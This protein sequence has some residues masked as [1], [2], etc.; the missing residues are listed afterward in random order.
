MAL[1]P[2]EVRVLRDGAR[3]VLARN[4]RGT[5]IAPGPHQYPGQWNWD[6]ALIAIGLAHVDPPR[7]RHEVLQLL[8]GQWDNGMVPHIVFWT[9]TTDY[10]PGPEVW[11][12]NSFAGAPTIPVT[13]ITQPP[14]LATAVRI[15]HERDPDS[16]FLE[17]V[18]PAIERWHQ[19]L[20]RE[21][22]VE[23]A[24]VTLAH[25]WESGTD[26]SPRFDGPLKRMSVDTSTALQRRDTRHV[27]AD[28]RPT[29]WQYHC[30]R[31]MVE[32]LRQS[33]Y[34][35]SPRSAPFA[36]SDVGFTSILA[37]AEEDLAALWGLVGEPGDRS[38]QRLESLRLGIAAA[39]DA[40]TRRFLDRDLITG[41]VVLDSGYCSAGLLPL[42]A[43]AVDDSQRV[44]MAA[45]M[46]HGDQFGPSPE[47]P[48][49]LTSVAKTHPSFEPMRYWRGP[50]WVNVNW[51]LIRGLQANGLDE[52]A[53][54]LREH[55][56]DLVMRHG[57][58]EFYDPRTGRGLGSSEFSW[59]AALTLDLLARP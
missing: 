22:R 58:F 13:G 54:T 59:T 39:W 15:L 24:L 12:S 30:Y 8:R 31:T 17:Q 53:A 26:D 19:W 51:F 7:A 48:W 50:V 45:S 43:G 41:N 1:A 14:V 11:N 10:F 23:D 34:R 46:W 52:D 57:M 4:D 42:Y 25:P 27:P 33:G 3:N 55:T 49:A 28:Q 40:G 18:L 9:E 36:Y 56:L 32:T 35:L 5:F 6:A 16:G 21:R 20:D 37:R 29:D 38:K 47:A 2:E 44:A